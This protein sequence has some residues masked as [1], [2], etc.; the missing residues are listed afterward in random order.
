M[1][2]N[3]GVWEVSAEFDAMDYLDEKFGA[4]HS[5][6]NVS[7]TLEYVNNKWCIQTDG[8]KAV[9]SLVG[10]CAVSGPEAPLPVPG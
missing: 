4:P 6:Q 1:R 7:L 3:N 10:S 5:A 8:E 2:L 9:I